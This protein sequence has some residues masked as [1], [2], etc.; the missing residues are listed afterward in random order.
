MSD[1]ASY[2]YNSPPTAEMRAEIERAHPGRE[3]KGLK[4]HI[5]ASG[6]DVY[7]LAVLPRGPEWEYFMSLVSDADRRKEANL[8]LSRACVKWPAP[9][10]YAQLLERRP[11]VAVTVANTLGKLVGAIGEAQVGEF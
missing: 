7:L 3:V 9:A 2:P 8:E 4:V 11:G 1:T 10:D 5:S 6:E